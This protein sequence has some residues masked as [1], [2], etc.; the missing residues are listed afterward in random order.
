MKI[1][2]K[3]SRFFDLKN[4]RRSISRF[5]NYGSNKP[6]RLKFC[7]KLCRIQRR[8]PWNQNQS[9]WRAWVASAKKRHLTKKKTLFVRFVRKPYV[10][11]FGIWPAYHIVSSLYSDIHRYVFVT[12]LTKSGVFFLQASIIFAEASHARHSPCF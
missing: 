7:A 8:R 5:S 9:E 1:F 3:K 6:F 2:V 4:F 11:G 10:L 12:N